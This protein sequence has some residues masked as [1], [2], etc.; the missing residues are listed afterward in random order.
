LLWS[1][2]LCC[3]EERIWIFCLHN[4]WHQEGSCDISL[5]C[6][7]FEQNKLEVQQAARSPPCC[8]IEQS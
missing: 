3:G 6:Q 5:P 8:C 2:L 7:G 4:G 1:C